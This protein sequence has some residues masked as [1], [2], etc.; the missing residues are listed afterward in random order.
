MKYSWKHLFLGIDPIFIRNL[1][2]VIK[3]P[4]ALLFCLFQPGLKAKIISGFLLLT[5]TD[6]AVPS[7]GFFPTST[8]FGTKSG[9]WSKSIPHRRAPSRG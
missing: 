3:I 6:E 1:R 2:K 5:D 4:K 7:I 9:G 8:I